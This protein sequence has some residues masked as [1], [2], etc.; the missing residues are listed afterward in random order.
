[1]DH[2]VVIPKYPP[3]RL[4]FEKRKRYLS[5]F[6]SLK[7]SVHTASRKDVPK[8][9]PQPT[10]RKNAT[11]T[12]LFQCKRVFLRQ[13]YANV[14]LNKD[15]EDSPVEHRPERIIS[16]EHTVPFANCTGN[17]LSIKIPQI[18]LGP[19]VEEETASNSLLPAV[20]PEPADWISCDAY[21]VR[22]FDCTR[23]AQKRK[24]VQQ[25][26]NYSSLE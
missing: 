23:D 25:V 6:T 18:R 14:S 9:S 20:R 24:Y 17:H 19:W 26:Q 5:N 3:G 12:S 4:N 21:D 1:M 13:K 15:L 10:Q 16:L 8:V 22:K 2:S 7:A 11:S